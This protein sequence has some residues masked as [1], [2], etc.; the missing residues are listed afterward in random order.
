MNIASRYKKVA[1]V[2]VAAALVATA[3]MLP[4]ADEAASLLIHPDDAA[5]IV[6]WRLASIPATRIADAANAALA[7]DDPGLAAS[8]AQV[9][10]D[11]H[12]PLPPDLAKRIHTAQGFHIGRMAAEWWQGI[13]HGDASSGPAFAGAATSDLIGVGDVRDIAKQGNAWR[14]GD[15]SF[16]PLTLGLAVGGLAITGSMVISLG[17][18]SPAATPT[19]AGLTMLKAMNKAGELSRPLRAELLKS[20]EASVDRAAIGKAVDA[21]ERGNLRMAEATAAKAFRPAAFLAVADAAGDLASVGSKLGYRASY[22]TVKAA[23]SV[24][25]IGRLRKLSERLRGSFRGVLKLLGPSALT[26]GGLLLAVV[27]WATGLFMWLSAAF[28][29]AFQIFWFAFR[30]V[31]WMGVWAWRLLAVARRATGRLV[32]LLAA[33]GVACSIGWRAGVRLWRLVHPTRQAA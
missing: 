7:A 18:D 29:L 21:A 2:A 16:D 33:S 5:A 1:A 20:A 32:W 30:S 27:G 6:N 23:N 28:W 13:I 31:G 17:T 26:I 12:V 8:L 25:D 24:D 19:D 11:H 15:P 14:T 4:R 10:D 3:P 22:D 9:A